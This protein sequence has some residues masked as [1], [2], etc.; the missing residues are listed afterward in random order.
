M[1][2]KHFLAYCLPVVLFLLIDQSLG[3]EYFSFP[4]DAIPGQF[5]LSLNL[6]FGDFD[7]AFHHPAFSFLFLQSLM[8]L[9]V[10]DHE[11]LDVFYW[12]G[13]GLNFTFVLIASVL[14]AHFSNILRLPVYVT[15]AL[16]LMAMSMPTLTVYAPLVVSYF[17]LGILSPAL[18]LGLYVI[19]TSTAKG[20]WDAA[21][22][23]VLIGFFVANL[24]LVIP[25]VI[26]AVAGF[27]WLAH[28]KG[29]DGFLARLSPI[30]GSRT[31]PMAAGVLVVLVF[32]NRGVLSSMRVAGSITSTVQFSNKQAW[33]IVAV[34][35]L[36]FLF[37]IFKKS[38]AWRIWWALVAPMA[39]GWV[40]SC[41]VFVD[42]WGYAA[43][44]ELIR[45]GGATVDT[46]MSFAEVMRVADF[47][48]FL[49]AWSWHW[50]PVVG[51]AL[52]IVSVI[53]GFW[54]KNVSVPIGFAIIFVTISSVLTFIIV[55]SISF[56]DPSNDPMSFGNSSRY[57]SMMIIVV[58]FSIVMIARSTNRFVRMSGLSVVFL[59]SSL[60]FNDYVAVAKAVMP[61]LNG[62]EYQVQKAVDSHLA[63][64]PT[65]HVVCSNTGNSRP[66]AMLYG[67]NNYRMG[68]SVAAFPKTTLRNGRIRY[69]RLLSTACTGAKICNSR[70]LFIGS[71][72][73]D[74]PGKSKIQAVVR[75]PGTSTITAFKVTSQ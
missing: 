6:P 60:A 41:N 45:R 63:E 62:H 57:I 52:L 51:V 56:I 50:F 33:A 68:K 58:A 7:L 70:T 14:V 61:V 71:P 46:S 27:A 21:I 67:L 47:W 72:P 59:V 35:A 28:R 73:D 42:S 66:C 55:A 74:F 54:R 23:L 34:L 39:I 32:L 65:N 13:F 2:V 9:P 31:W 10:I 12:L 20:K 64:N 75:F 38:A 37:L 49:G 16:S 4:N 43:G 40:V 8:V 25:V 26:G 5:G 44:R 69:E 19:A 15:V 36:S 30:P 29:L 3:R 22:V 24:F 53:D 17:C 18:G 11:T 48:G 1:K